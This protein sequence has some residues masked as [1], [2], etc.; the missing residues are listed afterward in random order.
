MDF[1]AAD[2]LVELVKALNPFAKEQDETHLECAVVRF[3]LTE[4]VVTM[5]PFVVRTE[6]MTIVGGGSVNLATEKIRLNWITKPRRGL[7]LSASMLT[8][9]YIRLGGTLSRPAIMVKPIDATV[10]TA[11]A[12]ATMG[13]SLVARGLWDRITAER[14]VCKRA[15]EEAETNLDE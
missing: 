12:V 13:L 15:I 5:K 6:R 2:I 14:D 8:N 11:A 3:N 4:G 1:L 9:P 7:G 10:S